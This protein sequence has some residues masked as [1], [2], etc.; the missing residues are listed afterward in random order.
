MTKVIFNEVPGELYDIFQGLWTIA[1][2]EEVKQKKE[3]LGITEQNEYEKSLARLVD[4]KRLD[5]N[6]VKKYFH[7]ELEPENTNIVNDLWSFSKLEDYLNTIYDYNEF[8]IRKK[9]VSILITE[10]E[11]EL[12][13][14]R[15][16]NL[17]AESNESILEYIIDKDISGSLKWE[18]YLMLNN[19]RKYLREYVEFI[20]QYVKDCTVE[21]EIRRKVTRD[22]NLVLRDNL[23]KYGVSYLKK[24]LNNI[25]NLENYKEI[26][27][28]TS[29]T[30]A[31]Y[32]GDEIESGNCYIIIGTNLNDVW[33]KMNIS[34]LDSHLE[35]LRDVLESTRFKIIKLLLEKEY[36]VQEIA[37]TLD[38]SKA[39]VSY[40]MNFL[41]KSKVVS[42]EK[43]GQRSY[44]TLN[45]DR[46]KDS[47]QFIKDELNL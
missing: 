23:D 24:I 19:T 3:K 15:E 44:Y 8:D 38:L 35:L 11:V 41:L 9:L 2:Q 20:N 12:N 26:Y 28:T 6:I 21:M 39:N 13:D 7:L 34:T 33:D 27:V 40:H 47:F 22:L 4:E 42:I 32:V 18:I 30:K 31:L 14:N 43:E 46:I 37:D 29:A 5:I 25:I 1:N 17:I 16:V 45:K 10:V 36:Y